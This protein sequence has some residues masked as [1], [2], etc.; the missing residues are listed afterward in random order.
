MKRALTVIFLSI[1]VAAWTQSKKTVTIS[2]A[3]IGTDTISA[4]Q[5]NSDN[6]LR[7]LAIPVII[8]LPD[9]K[10]LAHTKISFQVSLLDYN[11]T[12]SQPSL[13]TTE[14]TLIKYLA[15]ATM[16]D[17]TKWLGEATCVVELTEVTD[18]A[19]VF[20]IVKAGEPM[21]VHRVAIVPQ[22]QPTAQAGQNVT[23]HPGTIDSQKT[24]TTDT[25]GSKSLAT[26][27]NTPKKDTS[28]KQPICNIFLDDSTTRI[29][30]NYSKGTIRLDTIFVWVFRKTKPEANKNDTINF[31]IN[32]GLFPFEI[33]MH[34]KT[35][36]II[37]SWDVSNDTIKKRLPLVIEN[38]G[39]SDT[40]K[41]TSP[42]AYIKIDC[43]SSSTAHGIVLEPKPK[44]S[45]YIS[46]VPF[47]AEVG[48]NF[49]LV[50]KVQAQNVSAGIFMFEKDMF[51]WNKKS[52]SKNM[53]FT[54]GV[55][56]SKS[57]SL[58]STSDSGIIY[59]DGR[60][61]IKTNQGYPYFR[62]TG[63]V[64]TTSSVTSIGVFLSP[65]LR[66][67]NLAADSNGFHIFLSLY[68]EMLWQRVHSSFDYSSTGHDTT[69]Y[70]QSAADINHYYY[71]ENAVDMDYRS[72]YFGIGLPIYI[73]DFDPK[74]RWRFSLYINE[75]I[76]FSTQK[77]IA[78][79]TPLDSSYKEFQL[80]GLMHDNPLENTFGTPRNYWNPFYLFQFRL[81]E[82]KIGVA[83]TGEVRGFLMRNTKPIISLSLTKKFDFG[84]FYNSI[85]K[86]PTASSESNNQ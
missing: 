52:T 4:L 21:P 82:E 18:T 47:W 9:K 77:F 61:F 57:T 48:T 41:K 78:L 51:K 25:A 54:G 10:P 16:T 63:S 8:T 44:T 26:T 71:K 43:D 30:P 85:V 38:P 3:D 59:R 15:P 69:Y 34:S 46:D 76:G 86:S 31:V 66:L 64:K 19:E 72:H 50:D 24:G 55:Y 81:N 65:H 84:S 58:T 28:A 45:S 20:Y 1:S 23:A 6:R 53:S 39:I 17:S 68:L 5:K 13:A 33:K 7:V 29:L 22:P 11:Y 56:E 12:K 35:P 27:A 62:D 14:A 32:K 67:N 37:G 49:D 70:A 79:Q 75:A 73:K 2:I 83:F 40:L 36:V 74:N 80:S 60:S 42:S